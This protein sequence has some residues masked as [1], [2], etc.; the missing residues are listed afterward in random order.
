MTDE[1]R[2]RFRRLAGCVML[3]GCWDKRF[4]RSLAGRPDV[5]LTEQQSAMLEK[6]WQRYRR[7][8]TKS[9][10]RPGIL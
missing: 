8:L 3:P 7:Q 10:D 1:Q 2:E 6:L 9:T 4:V 5:E